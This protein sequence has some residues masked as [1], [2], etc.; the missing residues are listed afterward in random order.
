VVTADPGLDEALEQRRHVDGA[1]PGPMD[2]YLAL[3]G[4]R[5]LDVRLE[6]AQATAAELARRLDAHP[7]VTRVR[8]PGL[9]A[10]PGH[11]RAA[12]Q[13]DG[14]GAMLSFETTGNADDAEGVA[15][16]VRLIAHATS[17][18]GV[19]SLIERRTRWAG[20]VAMGTAPTL[21]RLSVGLEHV[22]DL[23]ADLEQALAP[24]P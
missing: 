18:G 20:E 12:R 23:W 6:R 3:R 24:P 5:T 21:L 4:L 22:E 9:P 19:E 10:D 11:V 1:V 17:L 7:A 8:Y 2:A 15:A 16:R 13:M 14:F